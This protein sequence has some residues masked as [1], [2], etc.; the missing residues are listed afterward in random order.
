MYNSNNMR[1]GGKAFFFFIF[2]VAAVAG[3][4][5]L[6]MTLWNAILPELLHVSAIT[7]WQSLGLLVLCRI[8]FGGFRFAGRHGGRWGRPA[9]RE[10]MMNMSDEEKA[11]FK[12]KWEERC[13]SYRK[14]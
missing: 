6:V 7:Y 13:R 2:I 9:W 12:S 14:G 4:G 11:A 10:K 1:R 5:A 3:A 8:L